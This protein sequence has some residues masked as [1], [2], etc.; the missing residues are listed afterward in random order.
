MFPMELQVRNVLDLDFQIR[1]NLFFF[2]VQANYCNR[3][4]TPE[5]SQIA[6]YVS[7]FLSSKNR[8]E[9]RRINYLDD[10]RVKIKP[11]LV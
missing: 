9:C 8:E 5:K 10:A 3:S 11:I 4:L 2:Y 6:Q 7:I 1:I